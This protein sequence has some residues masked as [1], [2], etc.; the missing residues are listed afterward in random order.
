MKVIIKKIESKCFKD[1]FIGKKKFEIM[2]DEDD[3][4]AGDWL[5]LR[6]YKEGK[7][8]G[9]ITIKQINYT[10]RNAE[11]YGIK[12]G[13][14]IYGIGD[15]SLACFTGSSFMEMINKVIEA[16]ERGTKWKKSK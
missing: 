14:V 1:V 16:A 12:Q 11:K 7:Y 15:I 4:I 6:E 2:K 5:V 10:L 3:A 9:K 13:Y 8:T